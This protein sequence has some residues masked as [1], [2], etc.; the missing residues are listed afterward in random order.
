MKQKEL[1]KLLDESL[2][3][4]GLVEE[5][6]IRMR[7]W[8]NDEKPEFKFCEN[9]FHNLKPYME[10]AEELGLTVDEVAIIEARAIQKMPSIKRLRDMDK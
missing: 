7:Y 9:P 6:V 2:S 5:Q 10:I 1:K 8:L 3:H 4:L